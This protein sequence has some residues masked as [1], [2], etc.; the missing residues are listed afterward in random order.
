MD[1]PHLTPSDIDLVLDDD[2][3]PD[4]APLR[5]HADACAHCRRLVEEERAVL[6]LLE[7]VPHKGPGAGFADRVLTQVQVDAFEPWHVTFRQTAASF[8]PQSPLARSAAVM[9]TLVGGVAI[10]VGLLWLALRADAAMVVLRV[11][12]E[13]GAQISSLLLLEL[14]GTLAG[15][16]A[17]SALASAGIGTV[18]LATAGTLALLAATAAGFNAIASAARRRSE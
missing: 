16:A 15:P 13:R 14:V 4:V 10:A 17:A 7:L 5:A 6:S 18:L 12:V 2:G 1:T 9:A 8:L 3:S 11:L